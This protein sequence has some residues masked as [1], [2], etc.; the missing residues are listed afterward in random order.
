MRVFFHNNFIQ[1]SI[2]VIQ[3]TNNFQHLKKLFL[4][5]RMKQNRI[6]AWIFIQKLTEAVCFDVAWRIT[7]RTAIS[8][9]LDCFRTQF[10]ILIALK[11][12]NVCFTQ[13]CDFHA[14]KWTKLQPKQQ[15]Q[16]VTDHRTSYDNQPN[17]IKY[18]CRMN[19]KFWLLPVHLIWRFFSRLSVFSSAFRV[20]HM[21]LACIERESIGCM[22]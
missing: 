3:R 20:R 9:F 19:W 17:S 6:N 21:S 5:Q 11:R 15:N 10:P 8:V 14:S 16:H 18:F 4:F 7:G 1:A 12:N 13:I 2:P 22:W